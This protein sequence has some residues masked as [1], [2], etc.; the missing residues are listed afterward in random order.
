[1]E[2]LGDE[3]GEVG[4]PLRV[5]P[6]VEVSGLEGLDEGLEGRLVGLAQPSLG[7]EG[8]VPDDVH[9]D[10]EGDDGEGRAEEN[11]PEQSSQHPLNPF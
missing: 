4:D 8:Q 3:P 11:G 9:D 5:A 2:L 10:D 1:M 6:G 7:D